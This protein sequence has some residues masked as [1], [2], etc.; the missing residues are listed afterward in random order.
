MIIKRISKIAYRLNIYTK[1]ILAPKIFRTKNMSDNSLNYDTMAALVLSTSHV[2][3][4][5]TVAIFVTNFIRTKS[6]F[7][8]LCHVYEMEDFGKQSNRYFE[9]A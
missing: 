7:N 9:K 4:V 3:L 2:Q 5:L 1:I 8:Y 6:K